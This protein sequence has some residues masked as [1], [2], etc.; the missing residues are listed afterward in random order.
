MEIIKLFS[1][2]GRK[3]FEKDVERISVELL[4]CNLHG[5]NTKIQKPKILRHAKT[6]WSERIIGRTATFFELGD[7]IYVKMGELFCPLMGFPEPKDMELP[8]SALKAKYPD[9][10]MKIGSRDRFIYAD[11]W[12]RI[13]ELNTG[14]IR[15]DGLLR[16][17]G[18]DFCYVRIAPIVQKLFEELCILSAQKEKFFTLDGYDEDS[19]AYYRFCQNIVEHY[20]TINNEMSLR[21]NR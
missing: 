8:L 1:S 3:K 9:R 15:I 16:A 5:E 18:G 19:M 21:N 11:G 12:C 13:M 6:S 14:W 17:V 4:S 2:E 20:Y 10:F 7:S